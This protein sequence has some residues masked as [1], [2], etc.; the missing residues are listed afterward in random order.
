MKIISN[1]F[2]F[3]SKSARLP[4]LLLKRMSTS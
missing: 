2:E 3:V 1:E 4:I